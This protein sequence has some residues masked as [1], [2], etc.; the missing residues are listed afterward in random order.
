MW[1][2]LKS[3]AV[4]K[5]VKENRLKRLKNLYLISGSNDREMHKERRV[6]KLLVLLKVKAITVI[7]RLESKRKA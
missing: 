7:R 2:N 1:D 4:Q 5:V 6:E 3:N